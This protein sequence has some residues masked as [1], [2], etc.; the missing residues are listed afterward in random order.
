M[1]AYLVCVDV[2]QVILYT[3]KGIPDSGLFLYAGTVRGLPRYGRSW[4]FCVAQAFDSAG[5]MKVVVTALSVAVKVAWLL[6]C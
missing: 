1:L 2:A 3:S 6:N 4:I 5:A